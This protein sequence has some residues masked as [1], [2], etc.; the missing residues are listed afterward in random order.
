MFFIGWIAIY[1]ICVPLLFGIALYICKGSMGT[2]CRVFMKMIHILTGLTSYLAGI[3]AIHYSFDFP[4]I[5][6]NPSFRANTAIYYKVATII[7][8]IL[9]IVFTLHRLFFLV[10]FLRGRARR[11]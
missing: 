4:W 8:V 2:K 3:V 7:F 10:I 1:S 9:T 5:E 6:K 11:S